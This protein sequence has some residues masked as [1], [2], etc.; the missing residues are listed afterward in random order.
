LSTAQVPAFVSGK[1]PD[2]GQVLGHAV[3]EPSAVWRLSLKADFLVP[4]VSVHAWLLLFTFRKQH[5]PVV[6]VVIFDLQNAVQFV[7][8]PFTPTEACEYL[9]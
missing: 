1:L 7:R 2:F 4:S 3:F 5:D 9:A 6:L 8:A